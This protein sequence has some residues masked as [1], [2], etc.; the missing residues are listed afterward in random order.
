[1]FIQILVD[2]VG[3]VDEWV[4]CFFE[5]FDY[6]NEGENGIFFIEMMRNNFLQVSFFFFVSFFYCI[7]F[8]LFLILNCY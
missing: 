4:V 8:F 5:E 6:V 3:L 7:E 1:M 2:V